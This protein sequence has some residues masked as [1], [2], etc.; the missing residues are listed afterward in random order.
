MG[1][2]NVIGPIPAIKE[3][4]ANAEGNLAP[5]S[6]LIVDGRA[7]TVG[8][9]DDLFAIV[10]GQIDLRIKATAGLLEHVL[11]RP[12]IGLSCINSWIGANGGRNGF[13]QGCCFGFAGPKKPANMHKAKT[14]NRRERNKT[15][16]PSLRRFEYRVLG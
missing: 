15:K 4:L 2:V 12:A 16:T 1:T 10:G 6:P 8:P 9:V 13:A 14:E 5:I 7:K 11:S 3:G